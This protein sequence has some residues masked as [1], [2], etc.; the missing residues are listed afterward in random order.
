ML[1]LGDHDIK[2]GWAIGIALALSTHGYA[3]GKAMLALYDM[4][5]ATYQMRASIH[6]Y[7]W[8]EYEVEPEKKAEPEQ[9][10]KEEPPPPPAPEPD[11]EPAPAPR[12]E[13]PK[14][15]YEDQKAAPVQAAK[16]LTAAPN[17]NDVQ[18]LTDQGIVSGENTAG[19]L[20][21]QS[22]AVGTSTVVTHSPNV[23]NTGKPGGTGTADAP[24]APAPKADLSKP[25][26]I[27]GGASWSNCPFPDEADTD[28]IDYAQVTLVVTVRPDGSPQ[29]VSVTADPGHG[30]GRAARMCALARKYNA[31]LDR[32]GNPTTMSTPPIRVT[33]SR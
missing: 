29:A 15:P 9:Q 7:L 1:G 31:G 10:K 8:T 25:A 19:P 20:G 24:P 6:E 17:P 4:Q 33:F 30:F 27:I 21:G 12:A 2:V 16:V 14:D 18:D 22:S 11:P 5:K 32:D 26:G 13:A 28:Q 23:S 3:S